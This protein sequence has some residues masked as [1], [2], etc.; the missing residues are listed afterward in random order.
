MVYSITNVFSKKGRIALGDNCPISRF[1]SYVEVR[2]AGEVFCG[3]SW[4][5]KNWILSIAECF[6][7]GKDDY[8]I[9][10]GTEEASLSSTSQVSELE[11]IVIHNKYKTEPFKW[12]Y[13]IAICALKTPFHE[14]RFVSIGKIEW[15]P[16]LDSPHCDTAFIVGKGEQ[17]IS[18]EYTHTV[19]NKCD[20]I[21]IYSR[22]RD[23]RLRCAPMKIL[24]CEK[25]TSNDLYKNISYPYE[26]LASPKYFKK[27]FCMGDEGGALYCG[28]T[29]VGIITRF[30]TDFRRRCSACGAPGERIIFNRPFLFIEW[31]QNVTGEIESK[32]LS[33]CS[34]ITSD[35]YVVVFV[36]IISCLTPY[37]KWKILSLFSRG[38]WL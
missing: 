14:T 30:F 10:A 12:R 34:K 19:T 7:L 29:I 3:G 35:K 24:P 11:K 1:P 32:G 15:Y 4:I 37:L 33:Y 21:N 13:N 9:V 25:Y 36:I 26:F 31:I 27:N 18:I 23:N 38:Q 17:Q 5:S 6:E 2:K 16:I 28:R 22:P 8:L 20:S